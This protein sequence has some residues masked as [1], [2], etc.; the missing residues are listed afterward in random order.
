MKYLPTGSVP[1]NVCEKGTTACV[2]GTFA[3]TPVTANSSYVIGVWVK[4]AGNPADTYDHSAI[5]AFPIQGN[6]S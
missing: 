6:T 5:V 4:S 2:S 3:W 1:V